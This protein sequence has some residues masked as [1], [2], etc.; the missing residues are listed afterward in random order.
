MD[1]TDGAAATGAAAA[2][3]LAAAALDELASDAALFF[4]AFFAVN[5]KPS[6]VD[7]DDAD[8][9]FALRTEREHTRS[10]NSGNEYESDR[11]FD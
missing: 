4:A 3:A 5:S 10:V 1:A 6:S 8:F 11:T 2:A 7:L 9:V